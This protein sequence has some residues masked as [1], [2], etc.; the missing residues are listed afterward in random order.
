MNQI[1]IITEKTQHPGRVDDRNSSFIRMSISQ[2]RADPCKFEGIELDA[3][4]FL[5]PPPFE[6]EQQLR[7]RLVAK[8]GGMLHQYNAKVRRGDLTEN[9]QQH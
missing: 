7:T 5:D 4:I 3:V 9:N 1:L 6:M 8:D 2:W